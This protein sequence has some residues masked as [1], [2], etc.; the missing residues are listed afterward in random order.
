MIYTVMTD[1]RSRKGGSHYPLSPKRAEVDGKWIQGAVNPKH[2]GYAR[3][4]VERLYG[5][6]ALTERGTL[7]IDYLDR[8][9]EHAH[10]TGDYSAE[11]RLI[12]AKRLKEMSRERK[13]KA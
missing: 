2:K 12:L 11:R 1:F 9:I 10:R 8:A 5:R 4:Y 6:E 13:E 3:E 7:R